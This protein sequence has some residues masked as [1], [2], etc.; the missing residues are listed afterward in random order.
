MD[1]LQTMANS[2]EDGV[3]IHTGFPN[4]ALDHSGQGPRLALDINQLLV[5]HPSSTYLFRIAGH[6]WSD[7]GVYDGDVAV[8]DRSRR[9]N[10][11]DLVVTWQD[12]SFQLMR[13]PQLTP[14]EPIWGVVTAII[15]QYR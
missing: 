13:E 15:H 2:N 8:I 6:R 14:G 11:R 1:N 3:S 4:P 7:Q 10:A 9:H 12:D 5:R